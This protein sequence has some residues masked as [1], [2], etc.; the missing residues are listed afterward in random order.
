[1]EALDFGEALQEIRLMFPK[2][3]DAKIKVSIFVGPQIKA[4]L[5]SEKL[6]RAMIKVEKEAWCG[7]L[8]NRKEPIYKQLVANLI[9]TFMKLGCRM[10]IKIHIAFTPRFLP[11]KHG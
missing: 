4:M 9:K 10:S 3:S 5:K 1:M 6:E 7:F 8:G 2:L 11:R